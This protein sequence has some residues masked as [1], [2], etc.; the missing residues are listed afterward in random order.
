MLKCSFISHAICLTPRLVKKKRET[1]RRQRQRQ[2]Q[3]SSG[4]RGA[5]R[6]LHHI[7]LLF[8]TPCFPS[9]DGSLPF[10]AQV[11][12][13]REKALTGETGRRRPL[14]EEPR[15]AGDASCGGD[16]QRHGTPLAVEMMLPKQLL[17]RFLQEKR[18]RRV[19]EA[20]PANIRCV[21]LL[22][23]G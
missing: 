21:G 1:H 9:S 23:T 5:P 4:A 14:L 8:L 3:N 13:P 16:Q 19:A 11:A 20:D 15:S 7:H 12:T 22:P 18:R 2:G 6:H 17:A 10:L